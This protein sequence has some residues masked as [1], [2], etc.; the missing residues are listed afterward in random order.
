MEKSCKKC[1]PK[2]GPRPFFYFCKQPETVIACKKLFSEYYTLKGDY[3]KPLKKLTLF[4]LSNPVPFNGQGYKKQKGL[5]NSDQWLFRLRNKFTK[6]SLLV[7][8]YQTKFDAV[9]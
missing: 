2:A 1:A 6:I 8:Y 5:G 7:I 4:F 3:Q 9:I